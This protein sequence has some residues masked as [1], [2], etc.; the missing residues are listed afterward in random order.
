M[1]NDLSCQNSSLLLD[2]L[3]QPK[4]LSQCQIRALTLNLIWLLKA[5]IIKERKDQA[6][7]CIATLVIQYSFYLTCTSN[8]KSNEHSHNSK[9]LELVPFVLT[10]NVSAYFEMQARPETL[11]NIHFCIT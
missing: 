8:H 10:A 9:M 6:C 2:E 11:Q 7:R 1:P 3:K 5:I 4:S